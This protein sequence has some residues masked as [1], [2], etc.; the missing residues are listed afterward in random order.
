MSDL[1][2]LAKAQ[3][4]VNELTKT[5]TQLVGSSTP[6]LGLLALQMQLKTIEVNNLLGQVINAVDT[7]S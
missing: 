2:L 5:I 6:L 7:Q 1:E 4:E 3:N